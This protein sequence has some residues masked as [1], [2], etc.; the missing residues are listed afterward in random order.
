MGR[1]KL[2]AIEAEMP[3]PVGGRRVCAAIEARVSSRQA[4]GETRE[5]ERAGFLV[6]QSVGVLSGPRSLIK[7]VALW[8]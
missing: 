1:P 6:V 4:W 8:L 3:T 5:Y 2:L 7:H